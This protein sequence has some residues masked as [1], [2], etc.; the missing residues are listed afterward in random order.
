[1]AGGNKKKQEAI[2][3]K[4]IEQVGDGDGDHHDDDLDNGDDD[5]DDDHES[6]SGHHDDLDDGDHYLQL[7]REK[8]VEREKISVTIKD[9][10]QY[11]KDQA[12]VRL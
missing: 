4:E 7:K 12:A 1:M 3:K 8:G 10:I 6:E 11:V 5:D 2:I 9:L